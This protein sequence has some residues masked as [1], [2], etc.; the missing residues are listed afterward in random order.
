MMPDALGRATTNTNPNSRIALQ[1]DRLGKPWRISDAGIKFIAVCES[2]VL[3][4]TYKGLPVVEGMILQVYLDSKG[5]PTV[6]LGHFVLPSDHLGVGDRITVERATEFAKNDFS[7]AESAINLRIKVPLNQ[8][9]Y[10]ALVSIAINAGVGGG[11]ARLV[12]KVNAGGYSKLPAFIRPYRANG[13]EWRRKL[14]A[15]LFET[16][17]YDAAHEASHRAT[18]NAHHQDSNGHH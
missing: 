10:D 13:I 8:H 1:S 16:G 18:H 14:E 7:E 5:N 12:D 9:E 6:G 11:I 2:G 4:G 15:R 3:N 17:N